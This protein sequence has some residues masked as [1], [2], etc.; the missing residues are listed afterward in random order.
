[1]A[2]DTGSRRSP[3]NFP[4]PQSVR[5]FRLF[6]IQFT[7]NWSWLLLVVLVPTVIAGIWRPKLFASKRP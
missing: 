2:A 1:M 6:G 5:L 4:A 3:F 7:A